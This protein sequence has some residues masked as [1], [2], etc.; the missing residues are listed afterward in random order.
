[1]KKSLTFAV[2]LASA[3]MLSASVIDWEL[4]NLTD[5][6]GNAL[7]ISDSDI[8]FL[9]ESSYTYDGATGLFDVSSAPSGNNVIN[10]QDDEYTAGTWTDSNT[11]GGTY[12]MAFYDSSSGK[13][14][15]I[16]DGNSGYM[17]VSASADNPNADPTIPNSSTSGS[18]SYDDFPVSATG[19]VSTVAQQ[20]PEPATAALALAG[21]AMLIRRRRIA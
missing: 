5:G 17:T 16:S 21:V 11:A 3:A 1:M 14:Y 10:D 12:A 4:P 19:T 9:L 20:V 7:S 18:L 8:V 13:Y 2:S 6:K 15:A